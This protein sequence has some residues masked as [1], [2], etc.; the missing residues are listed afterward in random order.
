MSLLDNLVNNFGALSLDV[1][2]AVIIEGH[3]KVNSQIIDNPDFPI[4]ST[5]VIIVDEKEL[6]KQI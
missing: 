5:D 2:R 3:V 6:K 4:S 1:A